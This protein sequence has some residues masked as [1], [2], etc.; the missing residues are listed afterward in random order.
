MYA[1]LG[2]ATES[3]AD[4]YCSNNCNKVPVNGFFNKSNKVK[5]TSTRLI[6]D[7]V[8]FKRVLTLTPQNRTIHSGNFRDDS[9]IIGLH[10]RI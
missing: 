4:F 2:C 9:Q 5:L 1:V 6:Y 10:F 8:A 3:K 7:S